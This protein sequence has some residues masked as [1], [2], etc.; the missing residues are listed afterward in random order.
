MGSFTIRVRLVVALTDSFTDKTDMRGE[1]SVT[2][3]GIHGIKKDSSFYV[4]TDCPLGRNQV[5]I[6]S[7]FYQRRE[8][9]LDIT[10]HCQTINVQLLPNES[11]RLPHEVFKAG[12][13]LEYQ[14]TAQAAVFF[15]MTKLKIIEGCQKGENHLRLF[16]ADSENLNGKRLLILRNGIMQSVTLKN[17]KSQVYT[18]SEPAEFDISVNTDIGLLYDIYGSPNGRWF[19]P[20]RVQPKYMLMLS[21]I[22]AYKIEVNSQYI[23]YDFK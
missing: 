7:Q 20:L 18:L 13:N 22:G 17:D 15:P 16:S 9:E 8:F 10:N 11:Y 5:V 4:F 3:G 12:G 14:R 21:D 23:E 19:L 6:N 2:V 1:I